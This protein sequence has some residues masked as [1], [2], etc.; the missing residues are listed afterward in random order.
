M[1]LPRLF[2]LYFLYDNVLLFYICFLILGLVT[3]VK[4]FFNFFDFFPRSEDETFECFMDF[5]F[6]DYL[7]NFLLYLLDLGFNVV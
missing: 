6:R 3:A 5:F 2:F 4:L 1:S 7:L